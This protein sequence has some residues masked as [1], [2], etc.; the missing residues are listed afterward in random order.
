M[1]RILNKLFYRKFNPENMDKEI[2]SFQQLSPLLEVYGYIPKASSA[3]SFHTLATLC[4]DIVYNQRKRVIEFGAGISTLVFARLV[5]EYQRDTQLVSVEHNE[6]WINILKGYLQKA[7]LE[8]K[9]VFIHAP[10]V[11]HPLAL[12]GNS[13]YDMSE[14]ESR[15]KGDPFDCVLVDGPEAFQYDMRLSR[16]PALPFIKPYLNPERSTICLDDAYRV[17]EGQ[18]I[19]RWESEFGYKFNI[20]VGSSKIAIK[21]DYFNPIA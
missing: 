20:A 5:A 17:G 7:G 15:L 19:K 3:L 11:K 4:N 6:D 16:Y 21:G 1:Y 14:A 18:V 10:K 13:W 8:K 12:G 9:V 2:H